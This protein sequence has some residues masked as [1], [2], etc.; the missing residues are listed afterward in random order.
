MIYC[1]GFRYNFVAK[2]YSLYATIHFIAV[3]YNRGLLH[4]YLWT[5]YMG[6]HCGA[7]SYVGVT[8]IGYQ[9]TR[10]ILDCVCQ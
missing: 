3:S 5:G 1:I 9:L 4:R 6:Y 2:I 10:K 8:Y 7:P